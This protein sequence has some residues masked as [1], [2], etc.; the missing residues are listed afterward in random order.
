ME[1]QTVSRVIACP[2]TAA[3][4]LATSWSVEPV[5]LTGLAVAILVAVS[6]V[7][8]RKEVPEP[9]RPLSAA[10]REGS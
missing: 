8:H 5:L 6:L 1:S 3:V 10:L 7:V 4:V 2:A 9:A